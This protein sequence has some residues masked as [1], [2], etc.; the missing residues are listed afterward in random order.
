MKIM[1]TF[2]LCLS[3]QFSMLAQKPIINPVGEYFLYGEREVGAGFMI[4]PDSSYQFYLSYGAL[5]RQ[6]SGKWKIIGNE[7]ILNSYDKSR[8]HFS[9][10]KQEKI[11]GDGIKIIFSKT[12]PQMYDY[13]HAI[14]ITNGQTK[15]EKA[16]KA[17]EIIFPNEKGDTLKLFFDWCPDKVS[18]FAIKESNNN[19]FTFTPLPSFT[20]IVFDELSMQLTADELSG[21]LTFLDEK[22]LRFKKGK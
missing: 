19:N 16:N 6:S 5:D 8:Q 11:Q 17:G 3:I 20:D 7:I 9:L 15:E 1:N 4:H 2:L 10:Q 14:L 18:V 13:L 12:N 21:P 22:K